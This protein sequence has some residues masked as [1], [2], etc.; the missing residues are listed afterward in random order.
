MANFDLAK[1]TRALTSSAVFTTAQIGALA[2]ALQAS[3]DGAV[4]PGES[5]DVPPL[6]GAGVDLS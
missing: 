4:V 1:F 2:D 6:R 5:H 3:L